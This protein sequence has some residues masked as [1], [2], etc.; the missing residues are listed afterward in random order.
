MSASKNINYQN[1]IDWLLSIQTDEQVLTNFF[2]SFY[3]FVSLFFPHSL[4]WFHEGV[5]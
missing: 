5:I 3:V 1:D 4:T 2:F